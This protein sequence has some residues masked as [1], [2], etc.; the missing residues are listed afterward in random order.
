VFVSKYFT[1]KEL[2]C[3]HCGKCLVKQSLLDALDALR[4]KA[5]VPIFVDSAYRCAEHNKAVGG[6]PNSEHVQGIAADIRMQG[7]NLMDMYNLAK[8][9][10]AFRLGGIGVYD[11]NF[12]HVDTRPPK[13]EKVTPATEEVR[14]EGNGKLLRVATPEIR[15]PFGT[16]WSRI[17]GKYGSLQ[18]L[19]PSVLD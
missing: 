15:V 2:A 11:G 4:D 8:Q 16:R 10:E 5:D 6:V 12:I 14:D 13:G 3:K 19:L 7:K 17:H 9:V 18:D 1:D